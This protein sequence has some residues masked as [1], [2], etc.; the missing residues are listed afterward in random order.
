MDEIL[1][2][3]QDALTVT[4]AIQDRHARM[5]DYHRE[6]LEGQTE[7]IARHERFLARHEEL[8]AEHAAMMASIDSKLDRL[9]ELILRSHGGNG[10]SPLK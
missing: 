5:I 9:E 1:K 10:D 8:M 2:K 6:W 4:I 3:L 7:A